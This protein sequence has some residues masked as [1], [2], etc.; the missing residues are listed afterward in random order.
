MIENY[1]A[2]SEE[3][4]F[5]KI[6]KGKHKIHN[7]SLGILRATRWMRDNILEVLDKD[8]ICIYLQTPNSK[9]TLLAVNA[10]GFKNIYKI[11]IVAWRETFHLNAIGQPH[12]L[13]PQIILMYLR[14]LK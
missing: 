8:P 5:K 11:E 7:F 14:N 9:K 4:T 13:T 1:C 10:V 2:D 6:E 3:N 12:W